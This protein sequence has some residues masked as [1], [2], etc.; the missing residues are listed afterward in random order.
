MFSDGDTR[1]SK[2]NSRRSK[3]EAIPAARPFYIGCTDP[4]CAR[5]WVSKSLREALLPSV[6]SYYMVVGGL[7]GF[8]ALAELLVHPS[9]RPQRIVLFD[10][11][12]GALAFGRLMVS[13]V[14]HCVSRAALLHAIFGRCPS[15]WQS[16]HG[17]LTAQTMFLYLRAPVDE[18]HIASVR[19][20]L[21]PAHRSLYDAI[22]KVAAFGIDDGIEAGM[23]GLPTRRVWPCWGR[24]RCCP[25]L[26][27]S[28]CGGANET[29]HYGEVGW[30]GD[31]KS[32]LLVRQAFCGSEGTQRAS[33]PV[34][35]EHGY[36]LSALPVSYEQ[37]DLSE[38]CLSE[39]RLGPGQPRGSAHAH[40]VYMSNADQSAK[41]L[42]MGRGGVESQLGLSVERNGE[43]STVLLASTL[44]FSRI[45]GARVDRIATRPQVDERARAK[46]EGVK[47]HGE[48]LLSS[49]EA[50]RRHEL[51]RCLERDDVAL[52]QSCLNQILQILH[53]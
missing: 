39:M 20:A 31:E 42:P 44:A 52:G 43:R 27:S 23:A 47:R 26:T 29:F 19:R 8:D 37:L 48:A 38:M 9:S 10:R 14:K 33:L 3:P 41:F 51:R 25:P 36:E 11:D 32:Y 35:D 1:W 28:L 16:V 49:L 30:L 5:A 13:L 21:P 2:L 24:L 34:N 40:V 46:T 7:S 53:E 18:P 15:A 6:G 45:C 17:P 12:Q 50:L 22:V 4:G